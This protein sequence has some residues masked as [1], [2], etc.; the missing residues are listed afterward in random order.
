[1]LQTTKR[2]TLQPWLSFWLRHSNCRLERRQL[3][4][5]WRRP[6]G[7]P[8]LQRHLAPRLAKRLQQP[9]GAWQPHRRPRLHQQPL[10]HMSVGH[11]RTL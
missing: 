11:K 8:T 5:R 7:R 4:W 6:K 1:M 2:N 3:G 10:V 9:A